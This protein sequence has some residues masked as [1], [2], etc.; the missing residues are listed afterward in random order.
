MPPPRAPIG[1]IA[2]DL[3]HLDDHPADVVVLSAFADERPFEGLAAVIDWRLCAALSH[4]R[5]GGFST[6]ALGERILFPCAHRL[7]TPRLMVFGLGAR[8]AFVPEHAISIAGAAAEAVVALGCHHMITTL[9]GLEHLATPLERTAAR[10]VTRIVET[11]GLARLTL[12]VPGPIEQLV[13]EALAF[14]WRQR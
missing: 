10:L 11:P 8:A 3:R 2:P 14:H 12:A 9:F 1:F 7:T 5:Q 13:R 4:W 6:G